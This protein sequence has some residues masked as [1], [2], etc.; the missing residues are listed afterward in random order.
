MITAQAVAQTLKQAL[1]KIAYEVR[2]DYL[3][4]L[5]RARKQA[6]AGSREAQVLDILIHNDEYAKER[7]L[8]LCQDTGSVWVSLE[9]GADEVLQ[10]N[11][12]ALVDEV[13]AEA[14]TKGLLR[15]SI[16]KDAL[17]ERVN[18]KD[19]TPAFTELTFRPGTGAT[20]HVM[21]KGGGSDNA[22]KLLMLPP[23]AGRQGIIDFVLATVQEKASSACPPLVIG[24]GVGGTF[25]T[26][27][28]LAKHQLLR[29]L[30]VRH[31]N[32]EIAAFETEL[33]DAVNALGIGPTGLGG[34][35]TALDVLVGTLPCHIASMP[36]AVNMGC[37]ALRTASLKVECHE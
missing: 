30:G 7:Q 14:Y 15:K 31:A 1:P 32:P 27:A 10:G 9:V 25:D 28:S 13:V 3:A 5:K 35:T 36:V 12:F 8:P 4:A 26:V 29:P 21:L 24:L 18:T 22:S 19:N 17:V 34:K 37:S 33:L 20:L 11:P 16:V 6:D 2:P 23:G